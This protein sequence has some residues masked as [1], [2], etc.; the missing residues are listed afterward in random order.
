[1]A[2]ANYKYDPYVRAW[3]RI[4]DKG[5][6]CSGGFDPQNNPNDRKKLVAYFLLALAFV[7]LFVLLSGCTRRIYVPVERTTTVTEIV[8]D[9]VIE[10]RLE[11]VRD[12]VTI[13]TFGNDTTSYIED[14]TH[15]SYAT[16]ENGLLG[17]SLGTLPG[18]TVKEKIKV[19]HTLTVDSIPYPVTV[20]VE[21]ELSWWEKLKI[22]YGGF[23]FGVSVAFGFVIVMFVADG[24]RKRD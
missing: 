18:A 11:V 16:W 1:M 6:I 5:E 2:Y 17:H 21:K 14:G 20:E 9:T 15:Y 10:F 13:E 7:F 3:N 22:E 24:R 23:A 19:I 4:A 8:K 12:T